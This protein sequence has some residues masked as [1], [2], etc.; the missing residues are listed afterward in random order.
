MRTASPPDSTRAWRAVLARDPAWDGR[1]VY[2]VTST[3]IFCRPTCP[4]RHPR[5]DRVRFFGRP[6]DA[7]AAGFRACKRCRPDS[8]D[9]SAAE[10]AV[11]TARAYL[12][13][14]AEERVSLARL[15]QE[16]G[17]SVWHLQRV[18]KRIVGLS[19]REYAA[20]LRTDR[21][22]AALRQEGSVSRATYEAGYG[23]SSRVYE[24]AHALLGMTP[25]TYRRGGTGMEIRYTIIASP[26]GRLLVA[27][28]D[29]G[30]AAVTLGASDLELARDLAGMFPDAAVSRVDAGDR[31]LA[32][33]VRQVAAQVARPGSGRAIPLDLAGTAFQWRVWR[34]LTTIPAG[35]T[36]TYQQLARAIGQPR[37]IRAVAS[38]CAANRVAVVV[39]CHRV[40]RTDGSLGG[41][42]WGLPR[43]A[44]LLEAERKAA[45]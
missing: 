27:A 5:R 32:G 11:D 1:F 31:W 41:Y 38:A 42:R 9:P 34:A 36:R 17:L 2:A 12:E 19:P 24:R 26:Y 39:P 30:V 40:V 37:A 15:A 28:T 35:E 13:S 6:A 16:A 45:G 10:R 20:A 22:R 43:K 7:A 25:A 8:G 44:R 18:F 23:S 33:L 14:H 4:S 3:R 29:K 21:L